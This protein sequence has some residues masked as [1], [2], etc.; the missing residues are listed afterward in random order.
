M[1]CLV[2]DLDNYLYLKEAIDESRTLNQ[3]Y[4]GE[5]KGVRSSELEKGY[6]SLKIYR[7]RLKVIIDNFDII[8]PQQGNGIYID[9]IDMIEKLYSVC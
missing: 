8:Q 1:K 3:R 2:F 6:S 9:A 4:R 5:M 7:R